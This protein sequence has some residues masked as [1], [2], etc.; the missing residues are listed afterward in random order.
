M[1]DWPYSQST[2]LMPAM[3]RSFDLTPSAATSSR[4][5]SVM[6]SARWTMV[7]GGTGL[8]R[9]DRDALDDVDAE[10]GRAPAQAPR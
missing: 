7:A 3:S 2:V 5:S 4:V 8:E 10:F 1:P 9:G 6:P